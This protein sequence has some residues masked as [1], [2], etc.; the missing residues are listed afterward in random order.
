MSGNVAS[1]QEQVVASSDHSS[2]KE[3]NCTLDT[4][5]NDLGQTRKPKRY[6]KDEKTHDQS[7]YIAMNH[8]RANMGRKRIVNQDLIFFSFSFPVF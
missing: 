2:L 6:I 3:D 1:S 4:T 7:H 5:K 8:Y